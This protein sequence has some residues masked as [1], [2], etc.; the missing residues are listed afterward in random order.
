VSRAHGKAARPRAELFACLCVLGWSLGAALGKHVGLWPGIA[1]TGLALGAVCLAAGRG[2]LLPRLRPSGRLL[3]VGLA[4]AL[5]MLAATYGLFPLAGR[6]VPA[7]RP[8]TALL[9]AS[10]GRVTLSTA[11]LLPLV[12]L[13]EDLVW[14]GVVQEALG[15]RFGR[16][17]EL[18]LTP[19][20]YAVAN[21]P[22]GS[23]LL[24]L[25]ALLCGFYWSSL[26]SATRSLVPSLVAHLVWDCFVFVLL[27][28]HG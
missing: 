14:R 6:L 28:L 12:V 24:T 5:V 4:A 9:Y 18:S 2:L 17:G 11:L 15:R 21:L 25:L 19:L 26:R 7:V 1:A 3:L 27:P 8:Q 10:L 16:L 20:V 13:G 22:S 23:P